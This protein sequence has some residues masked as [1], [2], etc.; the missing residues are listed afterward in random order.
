M[1]VNDRDREMEADM[2]HRKQKPGAG[3]PQGPPAHHAA[4][5]RVSW[6]PLLV[7]SLAQ[8]MV[9]LDATI[10]N[11]ALPSIGRDL[12]FASGE[13]QWVVSAYVLMTGGL[14]LLGGRLS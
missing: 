3:S 5:D 8:F 4:E 11:V 9:I 1:S 12:G 10:V 6:R 7:L 2:R 14:L 13:L